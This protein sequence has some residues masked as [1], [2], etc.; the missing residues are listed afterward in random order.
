MRLKWNQVKSL[1]RVGDE[2][3]K[4]ALTLFLAEYESHPL[5]NPLAS[6]ARGAFEDGK[7][8]WVER[9][10]K[11]VEQAWKE[12]LSLAKDGGAS[13]IRAV[14]LFLRR[15]EGHVLGNHLESK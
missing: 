3:G 8:I 5:G 6:E 14:E 15:F 7:R 11:E 9:H 13:G 1:V 12:V 10:R 4:Q 2:R